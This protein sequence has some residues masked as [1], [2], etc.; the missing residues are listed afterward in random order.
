MG[1]QIGSPE[2]KPRVDM[3]LGR[4]QATG[5]SCDSHKNY[6]PRIL[7]KSCRSF[8]SSDIFVTNREIFLYLI[9]I[10]WKLQDSFYLFSSYPV[11]PLCACIR[12]LGVFFSK[13]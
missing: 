10:T 3:L 11:S 2:M 8:S 5:F 9:F 7:F 1:Q 4:N 13:W 12:C 6:N